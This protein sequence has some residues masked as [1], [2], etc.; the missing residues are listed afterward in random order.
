MMTE[1]RNRPGRGFLD[2][3]RASDRLACTLGGRSTMPICMYSISSPLSPMEPRFIPA[4]MQFSM[5]G[6]ESI[7][8]RAGSSSRRNYARDG[9]FLGSDG[10]VR[11]MRG[12][13]PVT[14]C[15]LCRTWD[16][17]STSMCHPTVAY[18]NV[19]SDFVKYQTE[20]I[21]R[22]DSHL[23]STPS[24]KPQLSSSIPASVVLESSPSSFFRLLSLLSPSWSSP[25]FV[26]ECRSYLVLRASA[27]T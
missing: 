20:G 13:L 18:N 7:Y 11:I 4:F 27:A 17:V 24:R 15:L 1:E 16:M 12:R 14:V 22:T 5:L 9:G 25:H 6:V 3:E 10:I 2:A 23:G 8:L 19:R 26:R 21:D